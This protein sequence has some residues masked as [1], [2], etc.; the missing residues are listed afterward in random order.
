M[1]NADKIKQAIKQAKAIG[2]NTMLEFKSMNT[3][4]GTLSIKIKATPLKKWC[5]RKLYCYPDKT[6]DELFADIVSYYRLG[7]LASSH[8]YRLNNK[9]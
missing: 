3:R 6:A 4:T 8:D 9:G 5:E 2:I 7:Q 1:N